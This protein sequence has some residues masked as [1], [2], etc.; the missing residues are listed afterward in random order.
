MVVQGQLVEP[1]IRFTDLIKSFYKIRQ[2]QVNCFDKIDKGS[3]SDYA[4]NFEEVAG[5]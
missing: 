3:K 4:P 1:A 5:A 2:K